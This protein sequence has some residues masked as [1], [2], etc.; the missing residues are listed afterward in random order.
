MKQVSLLTLIDR[1]LTDILSDETSNLPYL[2]EVRPSLE[3]SY[4]GA[5]NK[6]VN[7]KSFVERW[8]GH[9]FYRSWDL[10]ADDDGGARRQE[11][12]LRFASWIDIESCLTVSLS[13]ALCSHYR[14]T[15][16]LRLAVHTLWSLT[17][18]DVEQLV[19]SQAILISIHSSESP[20]LIF[21][22]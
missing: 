21:S 12:L 7:L 19:T 15:D 22:L 16:H 6:L 17:Y 8:T 10:L 3:F 9:S 14:V 18:K 2:L 4:E 13:I 5:K 11:Y 20:L 1:T